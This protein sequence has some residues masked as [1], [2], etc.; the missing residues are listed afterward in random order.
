MQIFKLKFLLS[1]CH[2]MTMF[3]EESNFYSWIENLYHMD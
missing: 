1:I 3:G 2:Q